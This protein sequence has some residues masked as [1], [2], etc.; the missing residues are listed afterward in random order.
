MYKPSEIYWTVTSHALL[1]L[2]RF[3]DRAALPALYFS[4][5]TGRKDV[6]LL[7]RRPKSTHKAVQRKLQQAMGAQDALEVLLADHKNIVDPNKQ[8]I[9]ITAVN[10]IKKTYCNFKMD[11]SELSKQ[12][13]TDTCNYLL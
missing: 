12:M 6:S 1:F 8:G 4:D 11:M 10:L 3:Y 9:V 13:T 7:L 2:P 5:S